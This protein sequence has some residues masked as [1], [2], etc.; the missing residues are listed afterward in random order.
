LVLLSREP[1]VLAYHL[2]KLIVS[3]NPGKLRRQLGRRVHQLRNLPLPFTEVTSLGASSSGIL[4]QKVKSFQHTCGWGASSFRIP[5][6]RAGN[7]SKPVNEGDVQ[8]CS[9][10]G[11]QASY[12]KDQESASTEKKLTKN[13][14]EPK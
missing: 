1:A 3:A 4:P 10:Q 9:L 6:Q 14:G 13:M 2:R 8:Y 5:P 12:D 7:S 11:R